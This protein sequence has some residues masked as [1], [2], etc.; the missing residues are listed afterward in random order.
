MLHKLPPAGIP[1]SGTSIATLTHADC[2]RQIIRTAPASGLTI[3]AGAM[4]VAFWLKDSVPGTLLGTWLGCILLLGFLRFAF[5]SW[6]R[7][8]FDRHGVAFWESAYAVL[9]GSTGLAWGAAA[10]LPLADPDQSKFFFLV[11]VLFCILLVGSSTLA[12]SMRAFFSFSMG[13]AL[14]LVARLLSMEGEQAVKLGFGVLLMAGLMA[15]VAR[16]HRR[17]LISAFT[18]RHELDELLQQQRAIFDSAGEGIVFLKPKPDYVVSCNQ[19]FAELFGYTHQAILGMQP[20]RWHP[21]RAQWKTLVAA[22]IPAL[23]AGYPFH[24]V[25]RLQRAD[26]SQFWGDVTGKAMLA[27]DLRAGTVWVISDITEKRAA[28]AALRVSEARFRELVRLSSDLYWEQDEA[29]RFTYFDGSEELRSRL[30]L[31]RILGYTRWQAQNISGVREHYWQE[32]I[33][34]HEAHVPFHDFVYQVTGTDGKPYW[35]NVSGNP[36]FDDAGNFVGYHG[37]ASDITLRIES[38]ERYRHLAYHDPLT[39]LPNRRLLTDRLEQSIREAVRY[40]G[41]IA[42]LLLDLDGFKQINDQHGHAAGDLVLAVVA[43]RLREVVRE[44]DTVARMGGDE[45]V[46]LLPNISEI[47]GAINVAGKIHGKI[48]QPIIDGEHRYQVGTS[49]G[50]SLYP[51]HGQTPDELLQHADHAMYHGKSRGGSSTRVYEAAA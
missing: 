30:P 38:E 48:R 11:V 20:W 22:S 47:E 45:F 27:G 37:V 41:K 29:F 17:T 9:T 24:Q 51:V 42:L 26:G 44:A 19:R 23:Q 32:H 7:Q 50:I 1:P 49:I 43:E 4:L 15:S 5:A 2:L 12:A 13:I 18:Q 35:M 34:Q 16:A 6:A 39:Q 28:E 25:L 31:N 21:D 46:V 14:P 10:W 3:I 36:R 8:H 33:R 40:H